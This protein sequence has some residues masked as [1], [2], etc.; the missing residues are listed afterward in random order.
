VM[1]LWGWTSAVL[2][3]ALAARGE[4]RQPSIAF[5]YGKRVP[6]ADLA[7][8][9]WVVV[10]PENLDRDGLAALS[11]KGVRV[12]AYLSLGESPPESA[13]PDWTLGTNPGWGS[14]IV[15]PAATGWRDHVLRRAD[16]LWELG[17]RGLFLDTLD[18]Y[19]AVVHG[20]E[21][22]RI[23][24]T[25]LA[26]IVR[27]IHDRHPDLKLFFNRGFEIIDEIGPLASAV[28][29]ESLFFGWDAAAKRYVEVPERDRNW[30]AGQLR[31]VKERFGIPIAVVDYLPPSQR[32]EAR[33]AARRIEEMGFTPWIATPQLDVLGV[34][35]V[36][37]IPTRVLMLYD[38]AETK[39]LEQSPIHRL[40]ALPVE[41]LGYVPEYVDVR[42]GLP[43]A[44]LAGL[45]AGIVTWFTD[46]EMPD[47]L[48]YPEWLARQIDAGVRVAIL[49]R[50]GFSASADFIAG[51]GLAA[52]ADPPEPPLRLARADALVGFEAEARP[53]SRGL[54]AWRA[55][56]P[57][58]SVHLRIG[59]ARGRSFDPIVT[60]R[61][62]GM[63]LEPY[64][65]DVGYQG[66]TRWI[67]D[68]FAF[69]GQAFGLAR[70]PAFST[71]RP[72]QGDAR[73][74]CENR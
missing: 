15:D 34:G 72:Q 53:R 24:R 9:D 44:P 64:L 46:D 38:G 2:L 60:A 28:A 47:S 18:S 66:R 59:D 13:A 52:S 57:A 20:A 69:L 22:Q 42:R 23:A 58:I 61:W 71:A 30:L 10:Q 27:A 63:A 6:I 43:Q 56:D 55:V 41:H 37:V 25:A 48:A 45:Y 36:E 54:L 74:V 35:S 62:G 50:P 70:A 17:Y 8:F 51:L 49:G 16:S 21:A 40:A 5:F 32:D 33:K 31:K 7:H 1:R 12:F 19:L 65:V 11:G 14:V 67:V 3:L 26:G 39:G 4:S 29:A 68:P 73:L